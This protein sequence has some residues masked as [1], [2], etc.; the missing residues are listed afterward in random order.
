M[1]DDELTHYE[2]LDV[3]TGASKEEIRDAYRRELTTA[4]SQVTNAETAKKPDAAVIAAARAEEASVRAAWQILS[5]PVQRTR[6][7][8]TI[9]VEAQ[10]HRDDDLDDDDEDDGDGDQAATTAVARRGRELTPREARAEARAKAMANRPPGLFSTEHPP[11]PATWPPGFHAPPPRARLLALLVDGVALALIVVLQTTL[12]SVLIDEAYPKE[13]AQLDHVTE[14]IDRL[15]TANDDL[16]AKAATRSIDR[17][18]A[19]CSRFETVKGKTVYGTPLS[20]D[21]TKKQLEKQI[22]HKKGKVEDVQSDLRN[23]ILPGQL[24]VSLIT[25]ALALLYLVPSSVRSGRTLGKKLLQIRLVYDTGAP[26]T[27]RGAALHY[28][29]P[30]MVALLFAPILGPLGYVAVLFGVLT[31]PRNANYQGLH[32]RL[33]HTIVVDG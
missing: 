7:D 18:N 8:E 16:G 9:G 14:C 17:A 32:D 20:A 22:D 24:G 21:S 31:W 4:Q 3:D 15:D 25:I 23:D 30:V 11:T 19:E 10:P 33:A 13:T 26:V 5:D 6:Y 2:V 1:S 12:G 27:L 28:G 29:V